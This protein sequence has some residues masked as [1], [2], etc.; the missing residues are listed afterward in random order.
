[1]EVSKAAGLSSAE[2]AYVTSAFDHPRCE[3]QLIRSLKDEDILAGEKQPHAN[4][5]RGFPNRERLPVEAPSGPMNDTELGLNRTQ[6]STAGAKTPLS[7]GLTLRSHSLL[8]ARTST[9]R[10][11]TASH[12]SLSASLAG[13]MIATTPA[14]PPTGFTRQVLG[15]P[16]ALTTT[17]SVYGAGGR[18]PPLPV[19]GTEVW[20]RDVYGPQTTSYNSA[21]SRKDAHV[22]K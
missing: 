22:N 20:Q 6:R 1:M 5:L 21:F 8:P 16:P 9:A 12:R 4:L 13:A 18:V 11:S 7:T 15:K 14:P 19:S 17:S 3:R 2:A 10:T